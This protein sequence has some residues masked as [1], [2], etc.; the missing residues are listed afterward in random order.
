ML[1]PGERDED[2]LDENTIVSMIRQ[3]E[4]TLPEELRTAKSAVE[5]IQ[6]ERKVVYKF[7]ATIASTFACG[8]VFLL[9]DAAHLMPPFGGQG[10]NSGLRDAHNLCWKL[11]L[12]IEEHASPRLLTS[13]QQERYIHA[14]RMITFS[15]L[16]GK[17]IMPTNPLL[18]WARDR[19]IL[20]ISHIPFVHT[21]LSEMRIKPQ[22]RHT[23]GFLLPEKGSQLVGRLLPQPYVMHSGASVRLDEVLGDGFTLL[24]LYEKPDEAFIGFEGELWTQLNLRCVCVLPETMGKSKRFDAIENSNSPRQKVIIDTASILTKF[25]HNRQDLLVL[26]RFD[27][28]I[29]AF[30]HVKRIKDTESALLDFLSKD[31]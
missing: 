27:H 4:A 7:Y 8:R 9:G 11:K 14:A 18:A 29:T 20:G 19:F 31:T 23:Q 6:I 1:K 15:S 3:A 28:Y 30:F 10:M 25:L 17:L 21:Q 2:L 16:L 12:V 13:Y 26:V 22:P 5:Q 24:R